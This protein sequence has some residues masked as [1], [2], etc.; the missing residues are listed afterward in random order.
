[1]AV[2]EQA[3]QQASLRPSVAY[4][5]SR[6]DGFVATVS[7]RIGGPIGRHAAPGGRWWNPLRVALLTGTLVYLAG[8]LFRLPCRRNLANA[9]KDLCYSDI[10]LLYP[11][12]GLMAG[13]TPYLDSGDYPVLE[14]PVLTGYFLELERILTRVLGGLQGTDLSPEQQ[15]HSTWVF[16]AMNTVLLGGLFLVAIWAQVRTVPT[17]PWDGMMLTASPCVAAAA[18]INWDLL[19]LR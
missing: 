14:Y 3:K 1:V 2:S 12:R 15:T 17:R 11:G 13:N 19:R 6:T 5:P 10:P 7:Q 4:A 18:L 8:V 16:V 9:Y